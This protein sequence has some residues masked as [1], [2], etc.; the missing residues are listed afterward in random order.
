MIF[1]CV[2]LTK[3]YFYPRVI[4]FLQKKNPDPEYTQSHRIV[5]SIS[6]VLLALYILQDPFT[7]L[8]N[9]QCQTENTTNAIMCVIWTIAFSCGHYEFLDYPPVTQ[10]D[11]MAAAS[12]LAHPVY[13]EPPKGG[14]LYVSVPSDNV[15]KDCSAR[16][17][18]MEK[19]FQVA[20]IV[21]QSGGRV[22]DIEPLTPEE[23]QNWVQWRRDRERFRSIGVDG[24]EGGEL[25]Q[26]WQKEIVKVKG[27][28]FY[29]EAGHPWMSD[30][31]GP[32]KML[33]WKEDLGFDGFLG[34]M[35]EFEPPAQKRGLPAQGVIF[36]IGGGVKD[37]KKNSTEEP[38]DKT[39][40]VKQDPEAGGRHEMSFWVN[41]NIHTGGF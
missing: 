35:G 3:T 6:V 15:C 25:G 18:L 17:Y 4:F 5:N 24:G 26:G 31:Y 7:L 33:G 16:I 10:C 9:P 21:Y 29:R 12:T 19:R 41:K 14:S 1:L 22:K 37:M 2:V 34:E 20:W 36:G 11:D 28:D 30:R 23:V 40:E 32:G 27:R 39:K 8:L 13:C 38:E